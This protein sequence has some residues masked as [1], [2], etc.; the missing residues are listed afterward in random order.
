MKIL[1]IG[2]TGFLGSRIIKH[3]VRDHQIALLHQGKTNLALPKG[4]HEIHGNRL[5]LDKVRNEIHNFAPEVILDIILS[6]RQQALDLLNVC[7][8]IAKRIV[9]ISSCDVY[10][11]YDV[12]LGKSSQIVPTPLTE[13]S[14]LRQRFYLYKDMDISSLPSWVGLDYEKIEVEHA[15]MKDA[16]IRGTVLRL[17]M[18]YGPG[19]IQR[20]FTNIVDWLKDNRDITLDYQTANWR[21]PWGY[22][23][24][25]IEAI[26]LA[27][28][29]EK[30]AGEIYH[31]AD[32]PALPY[33][34]IVQYIGMAAVWKGEFQISHTEYLPTSLKTIFNVPALN[35]KQNL[36]IDISKISNELG[37]RSVVQESEAFY[38]TYRCL[39]DKA[40]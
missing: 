39:M 4:I 23:E 6:S 40:D 13:S 22:V 5:E 21:G 31:V 34:E 19:D 8:G 28:T 26:C 24:N 3:L 2:G 20:R 33:A 15:I 16:D 32:S 36:A 11:A 27:V 29:H 25:V 7:K 10:Q 37:Y 14:A 12:F 1:L 30:A 18:I 38:Q 17:P 35:L 9:I